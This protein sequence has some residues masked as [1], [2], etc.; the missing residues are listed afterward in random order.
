MIC[1]ARMRELSEAL[2]YQTANI[3]SVI[4]VDKPIDRT[5]AIETLVEKAGGKLVTAYLTTG[6]NDVVLVTELPDAI[7]RERGCSTQDNLFVLLLRDHSIRLQQEYPLR[8]MQFTW[9]SGSGPD[10]PRPC[11]Q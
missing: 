6:T 9:C 8:L 7:F 4:A 10:R 11:E 1:R 2:T 5:E 3:L